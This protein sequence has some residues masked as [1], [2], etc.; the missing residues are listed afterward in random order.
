VMC[1]DSYSDKLK[2]I[3]NQLGLP[4][5]DLL[6]LGRKLG[7][8][9]LDLL[10]EE[11]RKTKPMGQWSDGIW[12]GSYSSKLPFGPMR[13]LAGYSSSSDFYY[14]TRTMLEPDEALLYATP[15]GEWVYGAIAA[16]AE[17]S[18]ES[19]KYGTAMSHASATLQ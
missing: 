6:H 1:N 3:L 7:S 13:K 11:T 14:N 5:C 9:I 2:T 10:E 15:I 4:C 8:K 19:S 12:E 17:A 16:V 18:A